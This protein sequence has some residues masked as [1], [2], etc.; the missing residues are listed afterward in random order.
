MRHVPRIYVEDKIFP[1][2][3]IVL[4]REQSFHL[5]NVLRV[6][7]K[8]QIRVFNTECGEWSA[9][10]LEVSKQSIKIVVQDLIGYYKR[11]SRSIG[12][13]FA[14]IKTF[15]TAFYV[16]KA[17]ELGADFIQPVITKR[18][19]V[20]NINTAKLQNVAIEA[21]CQSGRI[22]IP[23]VSEPIVLD[24][25]PNTPI[26]FCNEQERDCTLLDAISSITGD[27]GVLIGPEGGFDE[28]EIE[29]LSS[30]QGVRSV[31]L[32]STILRAETAM[33]AALAIISMGG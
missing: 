31:S 5:A 19:V 29:F 1:G 28:D 18:T 7:A 12:L 27:L 25:I 16:Q 24:K 21:T 2:A 20:R 32:G 22:S 9:T 30:R 33:I 10:V 23:S 11:K 8:H 4:S 13:F 26:I 15:S 17:T 3:V 6:T 14:P